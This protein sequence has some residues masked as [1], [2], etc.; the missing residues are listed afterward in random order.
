[1]RGT[2][3]TAADLT[4]TEQERRVAVWLTLAHHGFPARLRRP[5]DPHGLR[6]AVPPRIM[7]VLPTL[8]LLGAVGRLLACGGTVSPAAGETSDGG[9]GLTSTPTAPTAPAGSGSSGSGGELS[10]TP[11]FVTAGAGTANGVEIPL[12][13]R[14][15]P[16]CCPAERGPAPSGQP[17]GPD[18]ATTCTSDSQCTAGKNGICLPFEGV[19]GPGGC[20]YDACATD[21][22]CPTGRPCQCRTGATDSEATYCGPAGNCLL[23]SD[24]G[25]GGYCSPSTDCG[26]EGAGTY[27]CHTAADTCV[28]DSDCTVVDA[29][30]ASCD[31]VAAC[32]YD[33]TA[34]HWSCRQQSCCAP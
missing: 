16:A 17:Y 31:Q 1:V 30:T 20:S 18:R 33:P 12:Y 29:G 7:R 22:D 21:S 28:N 14:A 6:R 13:H 5:T 8:L 25:P 10:C 26:S 15:A 27:Y 24:C 3:K 9:T 2:G 11:A 23:D 34:Q 4:G 19:I 32:E